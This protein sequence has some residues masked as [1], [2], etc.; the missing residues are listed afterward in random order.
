MFHS[1]RT[2][3]RQKHQSSIP[4]IAS[5][6]QLCMNEEE[7]YYVAVLPPPFFLYYTSL[8]CQQLHCIALYG[9]VLDE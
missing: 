3:E 2:I 1:S 5:P 7:E 6:E 4:P 8:R 9:R